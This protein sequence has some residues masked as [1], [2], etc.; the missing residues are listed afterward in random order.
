MTYR[1][2]KPL[3]VHPA[4]APISIVPTTAALHPSPHVV[5]AAHPIPCPAASTSPPG[6]APLYAS[7]HPSPVPSPSPSPPP[8]HATTPPPNIVTARTNTPSPS[9][10]PGLS[11]SGSGGVVGCGGGGGGGCAYISAPSGSGTGTGTGSGSG[12]ATGSSGF[13]CGSGSG[14]GLGSGAAASGSE[15]SSPSSSGHGFPFG[16]PLHSS[17]GG[18]NHGAGRSCSSPP[19]TAKLAIARPLSQI[20]PLVEQEI[21]ALSE[22]TSPLDE[23]RR[24]VECRKQSLSGHIFDPLR[25]PSLSPS[26]KAAGNA[27]VVDILQVHHTQLQSEQLVHEKKSVQLASEEEELERRATATANEMERLRLLLAQTTAAHEQLVSQR[28]Q[29]EKMKTQEK[30]LAALKKE[31]AIVLEQARVSAMK[32]MEE[33]IKLLDSLHAKART[34][35]LQNLTC[36]DVCTLLLE[37]KLHHHVQSFA[38]NAIDGIM[39][40][41]ITSCVTELPLLG[42]S[43][44]VDQKMLCH[45]CFTVMVAGR[46][47]APPL[48]EGRDCATTNNDLNFATFSQKEVISWLGKQ[49]DIGVQ[50]KQLEG[51]PGFV[52][53]HLSAT[54]L[55]SM[56]VGNPIQCSLLAERIEAIRSLIM[57]AYTA[58]AATLELSGTTEIPPGSLTCSKTG[59]L[60]TSPV[61]ERDGFVYEQGVVTKETKV[62]PLTNQEWGTSDK[63]LPHQSETWKARIGKWMENNNC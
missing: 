35:L 57:D 44:I 26:F 1:P 17:G 10:T 6:A 27:A 8:P 12:S 38:R 9:N 48:L 51:L 59:K 21:S 30:A 49:R 16:L 56:K 53:L 60:M 20:L 37:I 58:S 29:A 47:I 42:V 19:P 4:A 39:L 2:F 18:V 54:E 46:V 14:I 13:G 24:Q 3:M 28:E 15:P 23:Q 32:E 52:I 45:A 5:V 50:T 43:D 25:H 7:P 22:P 63:F 31:K 11:T 55:H 34:H 36:E 61:I 41:H 40:Y 62:S 33:N